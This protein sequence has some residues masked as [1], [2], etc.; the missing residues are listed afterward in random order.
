[1]EFKF[2]KNQY[3]IESAFEVLEGIYSDRKVSLIEEYQDAYNFKVSLPDD[4]SWYVDPKIKEY[5]KMEI[6]DMP[7]SYKLQQNKNK[8]F[9][10]TYYHSNAIIAPI[11][12]KNSSGID[13]EC[14]LHFDDHS[15]MMPFYKPLNFDEKVPLEKLVQQNVIGIGN[16]LTYY[17]TQINGI[18]TFHIQDKQSSSFGYINKRIKSYKQNYN[19]GDRVFE[20][21]NFAHDEIGSPYIKTEINS[22]PEI[23]YKN[24]WL[25]I[26]LDYFCNRYNRN[27]DWEESDYL[28][29]DGEELQEVLSHFLNYLI[30]SSWFNEVRVVTIATSPGFFPLEY[31]NI[32]YKLLILPLKERFLNDRF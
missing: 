22:L 15:D 32:A 7:I 25:D 19:I 27:S 26:D 30:Q 18:P 16:F 8:V 24:I 6:L 10:E 1:M 29:R 11:I 4:F 20:K 3:D 13:I 23:K 31:Y 28:N 2:L 17:L 5:S 21:I 14:I 12:L 9:L